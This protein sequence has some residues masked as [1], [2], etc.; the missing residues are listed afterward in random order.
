M[1][2]EDEN[3]KFT[4]DAVAKRTGISEA[5]IKTAL[6]SMAK[7]HAIWYTAPPRSK[8]SIIL[9]DVTAEELQLADNRRA[10]EWNQLERVREYVELP[11]ENKQDFLTNYFRYIAG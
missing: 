2:D 1:A 10:M 7:S 8:T 5:S 9:R 6:R 11:D 4:I 3:Y